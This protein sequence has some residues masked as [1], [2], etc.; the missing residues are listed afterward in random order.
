M[1]PRRE[2]TRLPIFRDDRTFLDRY[3]RGGLRHDIQRHMDE[4]WG[5]MGSRLNHPGSLFDDDFDRICD[6]FYQLQPSST[7]HR[8]GGLH[9]EDMGLRASPDIVNGGG[10]AANIVED[11]VSKSRRFQISFNLRDYEPKDISLRV[12]GDNLHVEAKHET[13]KDGSKTVKEFSRCVQVPKEVE[14]DKLTSDLSTD[15]ILTIK[16]PVPPGYHS[17]TGAPPPP[18]YDHSAPPPPGYNPGYDPGLPPPPPPPGYD[19]GAPGVEAKLEAARAPP[20]VQAGFAPPPPSYTKLEAAAAE[21]TA[22]PKYTSTA[23]HQ[24]TVVPASQP[25]MQSQAAP[26]PPP[27]APPQPKAARAASPP[28][29]LDTPVFTNT[30]QGRRMDL[31]IYI[32]PPYTPEDLIVKVED[33]TLSIEATHER[34]V[35]GKRTS[36][37]STSREFQL[38]QDVDADTVQASLGTD[39]KMRITARVKSPDEQ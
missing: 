11:P 15:G 18:G 14:T 9:R 36:K 20:T 16:A 39:G 4:D 1:D 37:S 6:D 34:K 26:S 30:E 12:E 2:S 21:A 28:E 3:G 10:G 25:Q 17:V 31:L 32:G 19:R 33:Q 24:P 38:A 8:M 5:G 27:Q 22:T 13:V 7:A 29:Q 35:E 23:F